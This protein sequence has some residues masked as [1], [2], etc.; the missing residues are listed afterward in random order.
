MDKDL[1]NKLQ[2]SY[3]EQNEAYSLPLP[4]KDSFQLISDFFA[5]N[6]SN[7]LCLIF[8]AKELIAQWI[9]IPYVLSIIKNDFL[10]FENEI[11]ETYKSYRIGDKLILNNKAIVEWVGI[12]QN[13]VT[14]KTKSEKE[15]SG[16]EITIK[17]SD[18][19]KLQKAPP[20]RKLLSSLKL[21]K[22]VLPSKK[23][24]PIEDLLDIQTHGNKEFIKSKLCLVGKYFEFQKSSKNILINSFPLTENI[25]L[26]KIRNDGGIDNNSPLLLA[27]KL[28]TLALYI[29]Q[30]SVS[31]IIIDGF[32]TIQERLTDFSDIDAKNIPTILIT[33]LS[34]IESFEFI[35]NH[36]F[37]FFNFTR[38]NLDIDSHLDNSPFHVFNKKL[39]KYKAFNVI[40]EICQNIEL[41][42]IVQR[43]YSI[44]KDEY[45]DNL[46]SLKIS[47]IQLT[48]L[49]SRIAH[50]PSVNEISVLN[51]KINGIETLFLQCKMWLGDSHKPIEES[52]LLLKSVI[53][54]FTSYPSE[55]CVK[56]K[57]LI[58][59]KQYDYIICPTEEEAKA[60][61][62]SLSVYMHRP[63]IISVADVND[64]LLSNKHIKAI[65]TG[66][67]KSSNINKILS[68]FLFS[69]LTVLFYQFENKYYNSLQRRNRKYSENV[70]STISWKGI[71]STETSSE[72]GFDELYSINED[73]ETTSENQF[74]ILE[75][76]LKLDNIQ[77]SRYK[78]TG[79]IVDSIRARR[80]DFEND[81]FIYYA[82][83]SHKLLVI[84]DLIEGQKENTRYYRKKAEALKPGD[85][86]AL[87]N[88][89]R[90]ILAE[91]VEKSTTQED[92]VEVKQWTD[93]WKNLLKE[94]F[95]SID[96]DFK[97]LVNDLRKYD[98]QKHE[99]TI[100]TWLLDE[101]RIGPDDDSDL[102]SIALL[103]NSDL[104]NDNTDMVRKAI[105]KMTG[106]RMKAADAIIKK[107]K[108]KIHEF[109]D[110]S[111]INN[112]I[113][114]EE[115]GSLTVLRITEVSEKPENIDGRYINRLLQKDIL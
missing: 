38:E 106:W 85:I 9:S 73:I 22:S 12:K 42:T 95:I 72:R 110:S 15:S 74:D 93:L 89:D 64:N 62:A 79:D 82:S 48:N 87:I 109:A 16:A 18:V 50:I 76:E 68:S 70:R 20:S 34:E 29:T 21:V 69:E 46:N 25:Y 8:P 6:T 17:F 108:S 56:L 2:Y 40:K 45:D 86:I 61:N 101:N 7:K 49:V 36:G 33:D 92:L 113:V 102:I 10:E 65:L 41:E 96:K 28:S 4:L 84:N 83:E 26:G 71:G 104:L 19:I 37:E 100:R 35:G 5:N 54:K 90:D 94:Y 66:W 81:S 44:G 78:A 11:Y 99:V 39:K 115:L 88:T 27:N 57:M 114:I 112:T 105:R 98:C 97:K 60:L 91:L 55:K 59:T 13:G 103:T 53:K 111:I 32:A 77:Y 67:A 52:I 58:N 107:I 3:V 14:F 51:S 23:T 31:K 1:I 80:I 24:T 75:F 43:I 47:L 30:H 63:Q